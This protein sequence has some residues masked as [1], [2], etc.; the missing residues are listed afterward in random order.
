MERRPINRNMPERDV[1]GLK[2]TT[3]GSRGLS[4]E[5]PNFNANTV[6]NRQRNIKD[7]NMDEYDLINAND[8]GD[9]C[10]LC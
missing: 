2:S 8:Q 6:Q 7:M 9:L 10:M 5:E 3:V 1:A 4:S